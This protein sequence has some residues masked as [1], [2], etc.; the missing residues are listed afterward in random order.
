MTPNGFPAERL[1]EVL[2]LLQGRFAA[3]RRGSYFAAEGSFCSSGTWSRAAS[4]SLDAQKETKE[5]PGHGSGDRRILRRFLISAG[6]AHWAARGFQVLHTFLQPCRGDPCGRP[7]VGGTV[8]PGGRAL[9][10][11]GDFTGGAPRSSRP[12]GGAETST[13]AGASP[14]PTGLPRIFQVW[15]GEVLGPPAGDCLSRQEVT[16]IRPLGG[17]RL[18][19]RPHGAAPTARDEPGA[20]AGIARRRKEAALA[21]I[22][23][24]PRPQRRNPP[25]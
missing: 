15:V 21:L 8:R 13:A 4:V 18:G 25:A 16:L 11:G 3:R 14:R 19:G 22:F 5:A 20:M 17:G 23:Y 2:S 1:E 6:A 24:R 12:T 10:G 7:P 9:T